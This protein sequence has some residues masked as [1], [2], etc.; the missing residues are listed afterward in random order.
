MVSGIQ[1]RV[2]L[3]MIRSLQNDIRVGFYLRIRNFPPI[4]I[5]LPL[6]ATPLHS[7]DNSNQAIY[8]KS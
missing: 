1:S 3:R 4:L 6:F 5:I 7:H 2:T 8:L